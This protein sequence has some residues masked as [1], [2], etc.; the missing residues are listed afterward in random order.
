MSRARIATAVATLSLVLGVSAC[1]NGSGNGAGKGAS[2]GAGA[3]TTPRAEAVQDAY[4]KTVA[5]DSARMT[6]TSEAV[7]EGQKVTAHGDGVV[8]LKDRASRMTL[9]SQGSTVEQRVVHDTVYQKPSDTK[10]T[11]LPAGKTWTSIDLKRLVRSGSASSSRASDPAEPLGYI[12]HVRPQDVTHVGE[13]TVDGASTAH[14]RVDVPVS[15]LAKGNAAQA[16]ELRRQLGATS[17]PVDLWLDDEGRLR[18]ESVRMTLRPLKQRTPGRENTRLTSTTVLKF[19]DFG[20]D[21]DVTPPPARDTADVTDK[22]IKSDGS[23]ALRD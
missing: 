14:Y 15:T 12:E 21:A 23:A 13:D 6:L 10:R 8:D 9:T 1:G 19:S 7:T 22:L 16:D 4:R 20:T 3:S 11:G 5:A 18:Q 17:L 2:T